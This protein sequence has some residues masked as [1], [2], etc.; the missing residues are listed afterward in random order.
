MASS[1]IPW[2][3]KV[4]DERIDI[5]AILAYM[6]VLL[7]PPSH[8]KINISGNMP[9]VEAPK[10]MLSQ[11]FSNLLNNAIRYNDKAEGIFMIFQTLRARD[12][13]ESTGIGL[14]TVKRILA[15]KRGEIRVLSAPGEGSK[16][17]FT[18]PE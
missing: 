10:V 3:G 14:T 2:E 4:T 1:N 8:T 7:S 11:I 5:F 6:V 18:W 17:V 16:F 9:V 15:A 12:K 13:F